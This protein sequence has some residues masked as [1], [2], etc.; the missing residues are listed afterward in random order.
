MREIKFRAWNDLE[1]LPPQDLTQNGKYWMWLGKQDV[2]LMQYIGSKDKNGVEIYES[3]RVKFKLFDKE[4]VATVK[5]VDKWATF[6]F[7]TGKAFLTRLDTI[8]ND[9]FAE[10]EV[11]GNIYEGILKS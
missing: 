3:D 5:Y 1:M 11:I 2:N 6:G 7:S 10:L 4:Y 9:E 8:H